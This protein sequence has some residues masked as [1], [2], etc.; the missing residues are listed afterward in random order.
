MANN[1]SNQYIFSS[2]YRPLAGNRERAK[3]VCGGSGHGAGAGLGA[4][5]AAGG[6]QRACWRPV[7]SEQF[8]MRPRTCRPA[9]ETLRTEVD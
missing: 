1:I 6:I 7:D 9:C 5:C 8:R 3:R 4:C 2:A